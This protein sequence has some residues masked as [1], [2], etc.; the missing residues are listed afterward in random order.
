VNLPQLKKFCRNLPGTSERLLPDPYN[1]LVYSL[2]RNNFAYFKTSLPEMWRFS[3]KVSPDRFLELTG[4]PG[5]K[6]ARYRGRYHW[7]TI[8]D[9]G[10]FPAAYLRE[11]VQWSYRYA[12][13]TLPMS[14][15]KLL[16]T[17]GTVATGGNVPSA[18]KH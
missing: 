16:R 7:I 17:A 13:E 4:V 6:P 2:D 11:L 9:V 5:V 8:V 10:N 1:I 18:R 3:I 12:L 15:R 14:R